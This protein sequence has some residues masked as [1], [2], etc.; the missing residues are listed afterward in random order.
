LC[1]VMDRGILG[2][3]RRTSDLVKD[4]ISRRFWM[5][6]KGA[7]CQIVRMARGD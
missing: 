1:G 7:G 2:S 3:G 5:C 6:M 4:G